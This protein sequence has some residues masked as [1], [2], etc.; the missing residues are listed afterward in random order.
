MLWSKWRGSIFSVAICLIFILYFRLPPY[1]PQR[2]PPKDISSSVTS[3]EKPT[4]GEESNEKFNWAKV[5]QQFPLTS[6]RPVPTNSASTVPRIQHQFKEE[7][8]E[9]KS[10]RLARLQQ[11][12]GNFTHAWNGYKEHAWLRDEVKPIS[13]GSEDPFGGWVASMVDSLG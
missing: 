3:K 12:K 9:Q 10:I 1:K 5:P 7:K 6:I 8:A 11:V 13:G 2:P 4:N